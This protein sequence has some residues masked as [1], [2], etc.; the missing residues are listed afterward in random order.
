SPIYFI[1]ADQSI[2]EGM[3]V[4]SAM[5]FRHLP[6]LQDSK[7]IGVV[8]IGDII[9]QEMFQRDYTIEELENILWANLV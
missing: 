3:T 5:H 4:M 9:K 2:D 8:S 7:L 1:K 6:V